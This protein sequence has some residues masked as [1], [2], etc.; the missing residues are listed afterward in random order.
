M[1]CTRGFLAT[2][3]YMNLHFTLQ[4]TTL[5]QTSKPTGER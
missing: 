1:Q 3:Y 2:M 4:Y 5:H